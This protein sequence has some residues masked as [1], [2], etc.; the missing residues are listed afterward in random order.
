MLFL[1][2]SSDF[3]HCSWFEID[4]IVDLGHFVTSHCC[5]HLTG[6]T[7]RVSFQDIQKNYHRNLPER[8]DVPREQKQF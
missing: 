5:Q 4:S 3:K 6:V 7:H 2:I 8:F 1:E